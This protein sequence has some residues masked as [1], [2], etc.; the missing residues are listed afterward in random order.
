MVVAGDPCELPLA[1]AIAGLDEDI[2][3]RA[4][5]ALAEAFVLDPGRPLNFVH[6]LVRSSVYADMG[7]AERHELHRRAASSLT[8]IGAPVERIALHLLASEPRADAETVRDPAS[9]RPAGTEPGSHRCRGRPPHPGVAGTAAA[10]G[11]RRRRLRTRHRGAARGQSGAGDR[12]PAGVHR[13][14]HRSPASRAIAAGELCTA[15]MYTGEQ[16]AAPVVA[17]LDAI[18]ALPDSERDLGLRLENLRALAAEGSS[19]SRRLVDAAGSRFGCDPA[20]PTTRAERI[21]VAALGLEAAYRQPAQ[22]G[23]TLARRAVE[24]GDLLRDPGPGDHSFFMAPFALQI[25]GAYDESIQLLTQ[26]MDI[27]QAQGSAF[28][29]AQAAECRSMSWLCRG[30]LAEAEADAE[31][32]LAYPGGA[33]RIA[34]VTMI[35]IRLAHGDVAG[36]EL[37]W[38]ESGLDKVPTIARGSVLNLQAR[39]HLRMAQGRLQDALADLRACGRIEEEWDVRTP[40]LSQWRTDAALILNTAGEVDEAE[41]L[42]DEELARCRAFGAPRTLGIALRAAGVVR[43]GAAGMRDLQEAVTVLEDSPAT[44]GVRGCAVRPGG[45]HCAGPDAG[46][47]RDQH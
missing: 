31:L 42:I 4:A 12:A 28:A 39:A 47:T 43:Q 6:P 21:H 44:V 18:R 38:K 32:A 19:D 25:N 34:V 8:S 20:A 11:V 36:A 1:A 29:F 15:L 33:I 26:A 27:A 35:E 10:G 37:V 14:D 41:R 2:A 9:R 5:D 7:V 46:P 22:V 40:V 17:L 3:S 45:R 16:S 23:R 24:G 30:Y 13:C